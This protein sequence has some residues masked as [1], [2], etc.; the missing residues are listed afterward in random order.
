MLDRIMEGTHSDCFHAPEAEP[1]SWP[2][3]TEIAR[4]GVASDAFLRICSDTH[5]DSL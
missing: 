2:T 5:F 4:K 3:R 1:V